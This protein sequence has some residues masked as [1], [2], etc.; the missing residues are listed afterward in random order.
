MC[1]YQTVD[2]C[3][4]T[5]NGPLDGDDKFWCDTESNN[6][7]PS[8]KEESFDN[9]FSVTP[10]CCPSEK[11]NN[12]LKNRQAKMIQTARKEKHPHN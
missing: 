6:Q 10:L 2:G 5:S 7:P 9:E 11:N 4:E 12:K 3:V 1:S 8:N